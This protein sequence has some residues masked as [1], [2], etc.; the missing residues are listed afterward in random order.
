[1]FFT[2][3]LL[4]QAISH[5]VWAKESVKVGIF[6]NKPI[7]YFDD[8]PQGL[9][10]DVLNY[11]AEKENWEIE[12]IPCEFKDCLNLLKTNQ[13]DLMTSLGK[14]PERLEFSA[15]SKE[16]IWTFWGTVY[17]N[18]IKINTVLDLKN[19]KVG[20]R[21]KNKITLAFKKLLTKFNIYVEYVEFDNYE[22][23]FKALE[24]KTL[25]VVAV[26]NTYAFSMQQ[27]QSI[28]HKTAIVFNP[29]SAYFA[30]PRK[31][32]R[33]ILLD[34]IDIH[35]KDLK[36]DPS[37]IYYAFER[38]WFGLA[39]GY[40]TVKKIGSIGVAALILIVFFMAVWRYRSIII[41]NKELT[42]SIA[43]QKQTANELK[44][45]ESNL[46]QAQKVAHLGS[47]EWDI[48][49]G[50]RIWSD[51]LYR[52]L[53]YEPHTIEGSYETIIDRTHPDDREQVANIAN[54]FMSG[55]EVEK[56]FEH[57][58][59]RPNGTKRYV[60]GRWW[61]QKDNEGKPIKWFG[62][63]L[64][65]TERKRT[66][67]DLLESEILLKSSIESS[68]DMIILSLDCKYR[69]L[70]FNKTHLETMSH[71][72]GAQPQ[73][74]D[75]IFDHMNVKDDIEKLTTHYDRALSGEGHS[76]IEKYGKG[77]SRYYYEV[78]YNPIYNEKNKIIGLTVFAQDITERK[79]SEDELRQAHKM[80]SIGTLTGGV[81]HDFN[82]LLYMIVGNTELAL[83][84]I[85][86]SNP[87]HS[88]LE[89]IKSASLRAAGIVKQLLHFSRKT[90]QKLKPIGAVTVI[91]ENLKL[92]RS[93]IPSTIEIKTQLPDTEIPILADSIQIGQ[94]M[95]NL[96]INASHAME[97]AGGIL[98]INMETASLDKKTVNSYPDLATA[99]NYLKIILSDTGPGIPP[100]IINRIF[101]PYFT[102]KD[103]GK[104]S[105]MGLTVVQGIVKNHDGTITVSSEVGEGT[106]FTIL[107]PVIDE[108][109]E[110]TTKKTVTI[111]HGTETILFVDDEKAITKMMQQML[112]K[113]GYHVETSLNPEEALDLFQSKPDSFDIVITDMTMPQMT[114]AKFAEKLKEIRS[115]IPIILC[116]GHSTL[117][118][119][120][121]VNHLEISGYVMKPVSMSKITKAIR[122]VLDR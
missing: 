58:I 14:S 68:K 6:Q 26:N 25:D 53:G 11:V 71:V 92:L 85:P 33:Q 17:S 91:K 56:T 10:V 20:V 98:E 115:D 90:D 27:N 57:R 112:K 5:P 122:E 104:G 21:R 51:E 111:S 101:D 40:W 67:N 9:Y 100:E 4:I 13:L 72:Y 75:C 105:G 80:E 89:E 109:P 94:I 120:D 3:T 44:K 38:K 114:G 65:I 61:M 45:S 118:D 116:T 107:F 66:E 42:D 7:V 48:I 18:D 47:W 73:I 63:L 103:F 64:D 119:E 50:S 82:N 49:R 95:M 35:V 31:A 76:A 16:P 62:T 102:T 108:A 113:L 87:S 41:I 69:Y 22:A 83:E 1:M 59:I 55:D 2:I 121:K 74:G 46:S 15:Y 70:Y 78:Q 12:Y 110:I 24:N 117:V 81:A 96:C 29:F 52:I 79:Q 93:T 60:I 8:G 77:E 36:S 39:K 28:F 23:A 88:N 86:E 43:I 106:T 32:G 97:E 84:D 54:K 19:K 30:I 34:K 37:S 99:D